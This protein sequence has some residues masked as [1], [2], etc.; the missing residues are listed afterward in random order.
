[1]NKKKESE[2][3]L[4]HSQ[5][6]SHVIPISSSSMQS[7]RRANAFRSLLWIFC[8][9]FICVI[10]SSIQAIWKK[11][12]YEKKKQGEETADAESKK[13][14]KKVIGVPFS[15]GCCFANGS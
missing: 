1:M 12:L 13:K 6:G 7:I 14:K 4:S 10:H 15:V 5:Y 8:G 11:L 9:I 2:V 3:F